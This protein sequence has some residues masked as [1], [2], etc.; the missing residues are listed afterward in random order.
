M[1]KDKRKPFRAIELYIFEDRD[2][3][4]CMRM[5]S[6]NAQTRR[7]TLTDAEQEALLDVLVDVSERYGKSVLAASLEL[8]GAK[9][10]KNS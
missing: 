8:Q 2:N 1:S 3:H 6:G 4:I 10:V 5:S 9:H 7:I